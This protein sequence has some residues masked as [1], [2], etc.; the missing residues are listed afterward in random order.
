MYSALGN[1]N[2]QISS[3]LYEIYFAIFIYLAV[4]KSCAEDLILDSKFV[5]QHYIRLWHIYKKSR[6]LLFIKIDFLHTFL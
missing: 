2:S 4:L 5:L 6:R 3:L 1:T